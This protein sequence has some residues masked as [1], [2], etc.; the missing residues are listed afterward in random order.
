MLRRHMWLAGVVVGVGYVPVAVAQGIPGV[1]A[2]TQ[3][4]ATSAATAVGPVA[5]PTTLWS[6]LGC[7]WEQKE[8]HRRM[9]CKLP[10]GQMVGNAGA[11][12]GAI[13]GG[14]IPSCCPQT[15]SAQE[16]ADKGPVG[17]AAAV[18]ADEAAA[19]ERRAAVRYLGTVDCHYWPEAQE[20]LINALRGDRNECVR[21]EAALALRNGCCCSKAVIESLII[22]LS[23]SDRDGHP[24]ETSARVHGAARQALDKCLCCFE[25]IPSDKKPKEPKKEKTGPEG[26]TT[27]GAEGAKTGQLAPRKLD[28]ANGK[29]RPLKMAYYARISEMPM[30]SIV[31]EGRRVLGATQALAVSYN[32]S[33]NSLARLIDRS[34]GVPE[35]QGYIVHGGQPGKAELIAAK[36][37]NLWELMAGRSQPVVV[38]SVPANSVVVESAPMTARVTPQPATMPTMPS[39][40]MPT[41]TAAAASSITSPAPQ[42]MRTV[43]PVSPTVAAPTTVTTIQAPPQMPA[44]SQPKVVQ[45]VVTPPQVAPQQAVPVSAPITKPVPVTEIKTTPVIQPVQSSVPVP[46]AAPMTVVK[47]AVTVAPPAKPVTPPVVAAPTVAPMQATIQRIAMGSVQDRTKALDSLTSTQKATPELTAQLVKTVEQESNEQVRC[48]AIRAMVRT[49]VPAERAI[50]VL[51]Q[52]GMDLESKLGKEANQALAQINLR[53]VSE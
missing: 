53:L 9:F 6:F 46:P 51:S 14:L 4:A 1:S 7:S 30:E 21:Y 22:V 17:A 40:A 27:Q 35:T 52:L 36:P 39:M 34:S 24:R 12:L 49:Q 2:G 23:C 10:I 33:G 16:L 41:S 44:M 42:V 32:T 48:A 43:P 18:K 26:N 37:T 47:P 50:P 15:P 38:S 28:D 11:P 25:E 31:R 20:A 19:K 13:T 8:E 3:A 5:Q 45:K 29:N